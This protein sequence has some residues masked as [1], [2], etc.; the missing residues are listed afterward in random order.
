MNDSTEITYFGLKMEVVYRTIIFKY[1]YRKPPERE[2]QAVLVNGCNIKDI[3]NDMAIAE[4]EH[5][6]KEMN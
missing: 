6:A 5:I 2:L 1:Y 3:L 4:I